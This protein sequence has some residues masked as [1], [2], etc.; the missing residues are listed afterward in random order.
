M[1]TAREES[2]SAVMEGAPAEGD[3][4]AIQPAAQDAR[5]P[6]TKAPAPEPTFDRATSER[7][8]V[9]EAA[10]RTL[11]ALDEGRAWIELDPAIASHL[12]AHA[13]RLRGHLARLQ[14]DRAVRASEPTRLMLRRLER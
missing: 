5:A 6:R 11:E 12:L 1:S 3:A 8:R 14:D 9:A 7:L 4:R 13:E 10:A 2:S